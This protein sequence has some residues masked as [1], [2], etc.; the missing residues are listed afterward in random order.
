MGF[1]DLLEH[2][3]NVMADSGFI[4]RDLLALRGAHSK[5]PAPQATTKTCLI[6]RARI[7]VKRERSVV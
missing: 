1:L 2:E 7:H 3:D 4:I 6:A 5:Q